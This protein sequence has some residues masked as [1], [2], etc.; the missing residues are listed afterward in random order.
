MC[1]VDAVAAKAVG[2]TSP[3]IEP[4]MTGLRPTRS[5]S[6]P[7]KGAVS[8]TA[9]VVALTV[10]LTRAVGAWN[11]LTNSGSSV[12]VAYRSRNVQK[13]ASATATTRQSRPEGCGWVTG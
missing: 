1:S 13:P 5:A 2:T 11:S 10:R 12:R 8:A 6:S 9:S 4:T 3:K 7:A